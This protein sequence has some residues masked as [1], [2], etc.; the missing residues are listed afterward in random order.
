LEHGVNS[1]A[2]EGAMSLTPDEKHLIFA[3]ERTPFVI[4]MPKPLTMAEFDRLV[5]STLNG[6]GNIYTISIHTLGLDENARGQ[7]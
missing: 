2:D 6:H 3:S 7:R 5:H 4:P 1:V